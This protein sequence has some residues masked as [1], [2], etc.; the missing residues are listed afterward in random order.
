MRKKKII[1]WSQVVDYTEAIT[2]VFPC[3]AKERITSRES[4]IKAI[5][6][7]TLMRDNR[8]HHFYLILNE[9]VVKMGTNMRTVQKMLE[10]YPLF[11]WEGNHPSYASK[12]AKK[13]QAT[14]YLLK[15]IDEMIMILNSPV[16][17]YWK[18]KDAQRGVFSLLA[19]TPPRPAKGDV[20]YSCIAHADTK[21]VLGYVTEN[22]DDI[23]ANNLLCVLRA[24]NIAK[25]N[26]DMLTQ[27]YFRGDC[28]RLFGNGPESLQNVPKMVRSKAFKGCF[29]YDFVNAH[30]TIASH[31][32]EDKYIQDYADN[33][34]AFRVIL[35]DELDVDTKDVKAGLLM[36]ICGVGRTLR[37][38]S[39][40]VELFGKEKA[41]E[42]LLHPKIKNIIE[43][44]DRLQIDLSTNGYVP[45]DT[46]ESVGSLMSNFLMSQESIILDACIDRVKPELLLFDGF[47]SREDK[48]VEWLEGI[49]YTET[50]FDIRVS[51]KQL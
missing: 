3:F 13:Y 29:E 6:C 31:F 48:A 45:T 11:V 19:N 39:S 20:D 30:Y 32:T 38:G 27:E 8:G 41:R 35:A 36:L 9:D 51:R 21:G 40:L 34:N 18:R 7:A 26:R 28:G 24:F 37:A 47:I 46:N 16:R 2:R 50:G 23:D 49:I 4:L 22:K 1:T 15:V 17:V 33:A 5:S 14:G 12:E 42:F 43:G 25:E 10:K 44:I